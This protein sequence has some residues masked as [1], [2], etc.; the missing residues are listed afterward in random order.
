MTTRFELQPAENELQELADQ[1]WQRSCNREREL[2]TEAFEAG[3][4]IREGD[5]TQTNL[6]AIVRWKSER[7]VHFLIGNGNDRIRRALEVAA[8]PESSTRGAMMALLELRGVDVSIASSILATVFPERYIE[9]DYEDL[10]ALGQ[11]RQDLRFYEEYLAFCRMIADKGLVQPQR[12][13]PGPTPLHALDRALV[14]W[15][16]NNETDTITH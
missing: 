2:E 13:L 5:Y 14:Q 15:A 11:V 7:L 3:A 16:R 9:L 6:E 10:E 1:Y 12:K 8:N 4:S